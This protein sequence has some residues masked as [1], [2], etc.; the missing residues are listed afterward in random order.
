MR[1]LL[2]AIAV[3]LLFFNGASVTKVDG[4]KPVY[5]SPEEAKIIKSLAPRDIE[6]HGKIYIKGDY[7]FVGEKYQGVHII[8]NSDPRSPENIGFLQIYGNN[9]I[10]IKGQTLYADNLTDL[11]LIDISDIHHAVEIQRV[12]NVYE[13]GNQNYPENQA[14]HTYFECVD[15][16]KGVVVGWVREQ[17]IDPKCFTTY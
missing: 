6:N 17:L 4:L 9:D 14:Y 3:F 16:E 5:V 2:L 8:N 11:V 13:A 10:A 15:P 7:I 1:Q 12:E